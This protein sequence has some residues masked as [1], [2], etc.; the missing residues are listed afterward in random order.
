MKTQ[1]LLIA[2]LIVSCHLAGAKTF[3]SKP[4]RVDLVELYTSEGCSSCPPAERQMNAYADDRKLWIDFVPVAFHVD[5]WNYLGWRDR[6]SSPEFSSRQRSYSREW[7]ASRIFT[8]CF[9]IN[10]KVNSKPWH[11]TRSEPPGVLQLTVAENIT[12]VQF[13]PTQPLGQAVTA[14]LAPLCGKESTHVTSGENRNRM[15]EHN[16]VALGL[17]HR[18]MKLENGVYSAQFPFPHHPKTKALAVWVTHN[19]SLKPIQATGGWIK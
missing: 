12:S 15:L 14:W 16:F 11:K 8:P 13:T 19:H 6:F 3:T 9:V 4:E 18:K 1:T 7:K 10:G 2:G 17:D 5:Y